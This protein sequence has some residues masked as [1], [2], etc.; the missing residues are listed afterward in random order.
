MDRIEA[1]LKRVEGQVTGIRRM[2]REGRQCMEIAQQIAAVRSALA[3]VGR[4]ILSDEAIRCASSRQRKR[5][6]AKMIEKLF[7]MT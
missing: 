1:R 3:G 5:E 4:E 7:A 2:Y 6:F